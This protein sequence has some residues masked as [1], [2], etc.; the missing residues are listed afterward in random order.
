MFEELE[1]LEQAF[2]RAPEGGQGSPPVRPLRVRKTWKQ[3]ASFWTTNALVMP[4]IALCYLTV[5]AEGLRQMMAVFSMRLYKMP[6]PGAGLL[7]HYDGFDRIDLAMLMA[8]LLFGAVTFIWIRLFKELMGG[9]SFQDRRAGNPVLYFL[10]LGIVGIVVVGDCAIFYFGLQS[11][12]ASSWT[13]TPAYIPFIATVIYMAG[14][15]LIGAWH[16]DYHCSE[17]V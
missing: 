1:S 13:D 7:R 12:A 5:S 4:F 11:K 17:T 16:A 3:M 14:L 2:A 9:G 8:L 6:I 15:A 10:L